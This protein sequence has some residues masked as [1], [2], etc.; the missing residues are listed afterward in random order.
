MTDM[1]SARGGGAWERAVAAACA[2]LADEGGDGTRAPWTAGDDGGTDPAACEK[3][4]G[5]YRGF[6]GPWVFP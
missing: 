2:P 3:A 5:D 1:D 4:M 6:W